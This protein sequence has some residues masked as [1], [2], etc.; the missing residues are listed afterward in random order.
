M[1]MHPARALC[2]EPQWEGESSSRDPTPQGI[3]QWPEDR[4]HQ[5]RMDIHKN[6]VLSWVLDE[7][8]EILFFPLSFACINIMFPKLVDAF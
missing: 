2:R 8:P 4:N 1:F 6:T 7:N 3:W 5:V